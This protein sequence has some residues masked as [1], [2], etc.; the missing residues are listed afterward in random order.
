MLYAHEVPPLASDERVIIVC[1]QLPITAS[2]CNVQR[3]KYNVQRSRT[4]HFVCA[5]RG[6]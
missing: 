6:P 2:R 1:F 4:R 3:A 5:A